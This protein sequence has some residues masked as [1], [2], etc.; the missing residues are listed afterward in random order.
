M[1]PSLDIDGLIDPVTHEPLT[2]GKGFL[3]NPSTGDKYYINSG[4]PVFLPENQ[5]T[6]D[7]LKYS[8]F[9]DKISMFYRVSSI[10]YCWIKGTTEKK[11]K[12]L[13]LDLLEIKPG[14]RVLEVGI[15]SADNL[16]YLER[17]AGYTG[18][19]ISFGMLTMARKLIKRLKIKAELFQAEAEHLPFRDQSFDVVFHVGGINF[20]NDKQKA[21]HEMIRVAMPGSRLLIVD[22]TESMVINTYQ[23]NPFSRNLYQLADRDLSVPVHLLPPGMKEIEVRYFFDQK[24]YCLTFRK[25]LNP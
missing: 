20:F 23:R 24:I 17:K 13:Y 14:D 7:N 15:G 8:R 12:K 22:E 5:M 1:Y 18:V 25:P 4:I 6:G 2:M 16:V 3:F 19:D 21:L 10:V 9:Y 11:V